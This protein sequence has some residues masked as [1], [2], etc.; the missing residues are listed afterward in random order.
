MSVPDVD[1]LTVVERDFASAL[2]D[3]IPLGYWGGV[4]RQAL[5]TGDVTEYHRALWR[6]AD[7]ESGEAG[8]IAR[9]VLNRY[10]PMDKGEVRADIRAY[11]DDGCWDWE[12]A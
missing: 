6:T 5:D 8:P 7:N 2:A 3:I 9:D 1:R 12:E 4:A 10:P 11:V